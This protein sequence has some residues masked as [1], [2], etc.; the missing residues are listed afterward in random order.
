MTD[1]LR[2]IHPFLSLFAPRERNR[3]PRLAHPRDA[4]TAML[5]VDTV[6][7]RLGHQLG[8][9]LF[10]FPPHGNADTTL[11]TFDA[12]ASPGD[13]L[14]TPTRVPIGEQDQGYRR[15]MNRG[16]TALEETIIELW[17]HYFRI[18]TRGHTVLR[19]WLCELLPE[20]RRDRGDI[21]FYMSES[22]R[23]K[24]LGRKKARGS[25]S[26]AAFVLRDGPL[27]EGGPEYLGMFGMS[28]E[29]TL[30]LAH[31]LRQELA[32]LLDARAFTMLELSGPTIPHR[33]MDMGFANDWKGEV[34]IHQRL[35][36]AR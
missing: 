4:V 1:R 14:F 8:N 22:A 12:N 5:T 15:Q 26:T 3:R 13:L 2:H 25:H 28:S 16:F 10:N 19:D 34:L 27:W 20:D 24:E 32:E 21:F 6:Q 18:C 9:P 11:A 31:L 36:E 23:Y 30:V 29:T 35:E 17:K 33:P 7:H